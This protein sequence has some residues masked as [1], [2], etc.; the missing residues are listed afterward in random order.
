MHADENARASCWSCARGMCLECWRHQVGEQAWCEPCVDLLKRPTPVIVYVLASLLA[1]AVVGLLLRKLP[2][3]WQ[4]LLG[5]WGVA[6]ATAIIAAVRLY[7][8]AEAGRASYEVTLRPEELTQ[9]RLATPYRG[10]LRRLGRTLAPPVS[11]SMAALIGIMLFTLIAAVV[12]AA[13]K[14]PRWLEWE[15]VI[16]AWWLIWATAFTVLLYR[17]WRVASDAPRLMR[18]LEG[19]SKGGSSSSWLSGI[20]DVGCGGD[21]EGCLVAL[22][23]IVALAIAFA[24]AWVLVELVVPALFLAGYWFIVRS[25]SRVANDHHD[26]EGKLARSTLWGA[27][28]AALYTVPIAGFIALGHF[29]LQS[30]MQ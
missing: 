25:L 27:L 23:V 4:I 24:L 3:D 14:L 20:G 21:I 5:A 22:A 19:S 9:G 8:R 30:T 2:F 6:A 17:G 11:G 18:P 15:L 12:P 28:W 26:C 16:S 1:T 29:I 10:R 13:L 7:R